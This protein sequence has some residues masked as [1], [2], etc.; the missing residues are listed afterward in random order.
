M[1]SPIREDVVDPHSFEDVAARSFNKTERVRVG[2]EVERRDKD[3][4]RPDRREG[5]GETRVH[6]RR[7]RRGRDKALALLATEKK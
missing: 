6:E 5:E 2:G 7:E 3:R 4:P 1:T